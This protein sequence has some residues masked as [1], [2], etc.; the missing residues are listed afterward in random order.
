[1]WSR[2]GKR[3]GTLSEPEKRVHDDVAP[4]IGITTYPR[5]PSGSFSLPADY[6][7][8]VRRAGGV[9][10]LLVP[11]GD[12]AELRVVLERIDGLVIAGGGDVD[13]ARYGGDSPGQSQG[14]DRERDS[15]EIALSAAVV[16]NEIPTL[17]ICRGCQVFNVA[18]GGS[19]HQ[20][21][22]DVVGE[23]VRHRREQESQD[24]VRHRVV[25][26]ESS[27]LA[28]MMGSA[29]PEPLSSHHQAV[30]RA[31]ASLRVVARAADGTIEALELPG[32]PWLVAV[33]WHPEATAAEDPTQQRIF[34][35]LVTAARERRRSQ[36]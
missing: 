15:F 21:L 16:S 29:T 4:L 28:T 17:P 9:P 30:D 34:D 27:R 10:V 36:R 1:M 35:S 7:D 32:H 11:G 8:S 12:E 25:V 3:R 23:D 14:I 6:V 2:L 13:P 5:D 26:D 18:L 22:P 24:H 31:A 20:H 33:Q 19:L